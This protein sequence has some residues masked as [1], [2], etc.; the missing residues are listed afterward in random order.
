ME[1]KARGGKMASME[2]ADGEKRRHSTRL[3]DLDYASPGAYFVT[4]RAHDRRGL[5]GKIEND[6]YVV[7]PNHIHG[8]VILMERKSITRIDANHTGDR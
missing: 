1:E 4:I 5:F 2:Q 6:E 3:K 8:I 7:M